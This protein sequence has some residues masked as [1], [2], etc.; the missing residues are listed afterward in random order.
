[1]AAPNFTIEAI[2]QDFPK[3]AAQV[4][5]ARALLGWSQAYL[6]EGI[7]VRRVTIADLESCKHEP[8]AS[9]LFALMNELT[10]AGIVFTETGVEFQSWPPS[11]YVPTGCVRTRKRIR[12]K[13]YS[14]RDVAHHSSSTTP[15]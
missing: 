7:N 3:L 4:R 6:A 1:L 14:R 11:P 8:Q 2:M 12:R 13:H 9:T 10:A 5:G 15:V